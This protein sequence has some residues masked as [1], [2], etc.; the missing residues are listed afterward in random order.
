MTA[1]KKY[2]KCREFAEC[3]D[4]VR[5]GQ[6]DQLEVEKLLY[7]YTQAVAEVRDWLQSVLCREMSEEGYSSVSVSLE[8]PLETVNVKLNCESVADPIERPTYGYYPL[9]RLHKE[10]PELLHTPAGRMD[11]YTYKAIREEEDNPAA[12]FLCH[13]SRLVNHLHMLA[14]S[15]E[16]LDRDMLQTKGIEDVL[17]LYRLDML[18]K[19]MDRFLM[20]DSVVS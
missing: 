8:L 4:F 19:D 20:K 1:N 15:E 6:R 18:L 10:P 7:L 11:R 5:V 14:G 17:Q 2:E 9:E 13:L 16:M 12:M 3:M